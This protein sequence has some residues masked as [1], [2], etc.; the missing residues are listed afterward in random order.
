MLGIPRVVYADPAP[1]TPLFNEHSEN[2]D[3]R[4]VTEGGT[5]ELAQPGSPCMCLNPRASYSY[6]LSCMGFFEDA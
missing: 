6:F 5:E 3:V 2:A 1:F 4:E